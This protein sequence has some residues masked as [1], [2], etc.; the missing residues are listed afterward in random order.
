MD[1]HEEVDD[2]VEDQDPTPTSWDGLEPTSGS[3]GNTDPK[4]SED[5]S[6]KGKR[7]LAIRYARRAKIIFGV[8]KKTQANNL[9]VRRFIVKALEKDDVRKVD[10]YK[11]VDCAVMLVFL[12]ANHELALAREGDCMWH[13]WRTYAWNSTSASAYSN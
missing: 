3:W 8:P 10:I 7:V 12:P 2:V 13:R 6:E 5:V 4:G 1:T 9:A 11:N